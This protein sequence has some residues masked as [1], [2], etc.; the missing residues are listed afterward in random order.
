MSLDEI[1]DIVGIERGREYG[2][3]DQQTMAEW[4]ND[5]FGRSRS[6]LSIAIRANEEMSELLAKLRDRDDDPE[7]AIEAADVFIVL[8]RLFENFGLDYRDVIDAKMD[9]NRRRSWKTTATGHG[10]HE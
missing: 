2:S 10:Y 8:M 9:L 7:G 1:T 3:E 5:T 4:A 6:N